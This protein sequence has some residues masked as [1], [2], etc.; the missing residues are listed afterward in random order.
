MSTIP[1]SA[2]GREPAR[3][4]HATSSR[5]EMTA[6]QFLTVTFA[7]CFLLYLLP[8]VAV[9]SGVCPRW[10]TSYWGQV[11]DTTYQT[12]H[13][14]ADVVV[15]GDS[16]SATNFDP[17]RMSR[18][19]GLKVLELPNVS[20]SLPVSGFAP[21][22]RYLSMNKQPRLI[23]FYLSAW[24]MDFLHNPFTKID[25]EGEEMLLMHGSWS[26]L[27]LYASRSPRK[28]VLF[29]LHFYASSNRIADLVYFREHEDP[30]VERGHL[31]LTHEAPM[32]PTCEFDPIRVRSSAAD[33]SVRE[34]VRQFTT[35]GTQTVVVISPLPRCKHI[36]VIQQI[37]HTGL[38]IPPIQVLPPPSFRED[39][40][41]AHM[42]STAIRPSTEY[43]EGVV[44]TRLS[45]SA[46][47]VASR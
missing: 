14:D 1:I 38:D 30:K 36:E 33:A 18:D 24:D 31:Q 47:L 6:R 44:R 37:T 9:R 7:V 13:Q 27:L 34:G 39:S 10:T 25:V 16:T 45:P 23:I 20:T 19:L 15:F 2:L 21:L 17:D 42:L 26:D 4:E 8:F 41:Q 40:W 5:A 3:A 43:L 32:A 35:P 22:K 29:P 12:A 46:G 28:V 11:I